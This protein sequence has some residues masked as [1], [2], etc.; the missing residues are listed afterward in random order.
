MCAD[1]QVGEMGKEG[2]GDD[3]EDTGLAGLAGT[4]SRLVES[5]LRSK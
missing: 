3:T 4:C 1:T 5:L 2:G